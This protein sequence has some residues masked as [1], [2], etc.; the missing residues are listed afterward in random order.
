MKITL[1]LKET[2]SFLRWLMLPAQI[3]R[4]ELITSSMFR[5]K[6]IPHFHCLLYLVASLEV[7]NVWYKFVTPLRDKLQEL[8]LRWLFCVCNRKI[9]FG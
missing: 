3:C 1:A 2:P 4:W 7:L 9:P 5:T 6:A 8:L